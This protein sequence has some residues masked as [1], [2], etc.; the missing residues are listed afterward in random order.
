MIL[1]KIFMRNYIGKDIDA[2]IREKYGIF[3]SIVGIVC[4]ILLS[5]SKMLVGLFFG[6]VA[7]L[8]D[9]LN[10]LSDAAS[11][12]ISIIGIKIA[13][14]PADE[15][16]PFGHGRYE[17]IA[18]LIVAFLILEVAVTCFKDS[19][20][21][22][23]DGGTMVFAWISVIVLAVSILAKL[24]LFFFYRRIGRKVDSKVCMATSKDALSDAVLTS[25]TL[26]STLVLHFFALDIDGYVGAVVSV[27]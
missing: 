8:A 22:I 14:K 1:E 23:H 25:A 10:N 19:I 18:A 11:A 12:I 24:W 16:H 15:E 9:G 26:A 27:M 7:I 3:A 13:A 17:Y 4:N 2:Q 5:G 20:A 21:K 6:S